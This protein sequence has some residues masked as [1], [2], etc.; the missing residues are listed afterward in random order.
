MATRDL[1]AGQ[2]HRPRLPGLEH[3]N[4]AVREE[5]VQSQCV[6]ANLPLYSQGS[7]ITEYANIEIFN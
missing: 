6:L 4:G 7:G 5:L 3:R 1:A 2:R